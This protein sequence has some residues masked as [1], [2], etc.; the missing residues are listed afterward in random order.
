M[1]D[2]AEINPDLETVLDKENCEKIKACTVK[3]IGGIV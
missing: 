2:R 1:Y 3:D